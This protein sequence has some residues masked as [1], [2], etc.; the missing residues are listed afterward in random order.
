MRLLC[1]LVGFFMLPVEG[2]EELF[3]QK[4]GNEDIG[5][6]L[7]VVRQRSDNTTANPQLLFRYEVTNHGK[8]AWAV[9]TKGHTGESFKE[10]AYSEALGAQWVEYSLKAFQEPADR[11]CPLRYLPI[12]PKAVLLP[13]GETLRGQVSAALPPRPH[14]PFDDCTPRPAFPKN[15]SKARFCLGV[16]RLSDTDMP[17][18]EKGQ[19]PATIVEHQELLCSDLFDMVGS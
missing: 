16:S 3:R 12:T 6:E 4:I 17:F 15:V 18:V 11:N 1:L 8:D 2:A 10:G 7:I 13:A 9:F 19:T 5:L 14:T